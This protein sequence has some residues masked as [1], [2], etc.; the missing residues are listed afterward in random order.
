MER[1]PSTKSYGESRFYPRFKRDFQEL[2]L[3][4]LEIH[5][6]MFTLRLCL[7]KDVEAILGSGDFDLEQIFKRLDEKYGDPSK[8]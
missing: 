5:E 3:P 7:G 1:L 8:V 6:A 4:H 2:V